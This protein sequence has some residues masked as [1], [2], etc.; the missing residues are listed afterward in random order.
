[1][2]NTQA[3]QWKEIK[4]KIKATWGRLTDDDLT[5]IDGRREELVGKLQQRY[6][7]QREEIDREVERFYAN[8]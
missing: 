7:K 4:G 8:L 3:G 6:G 2:P 5:E 1:M